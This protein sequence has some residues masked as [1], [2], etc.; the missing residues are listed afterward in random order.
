MTVKTLV[1]TCALSTIALTA[2][3][4]AAPDFTAQSTDPVIQWNR[5]LLAIVPD[6]WC[7]G[8]HDSSTRSF[9]IMHAAIY[10]AVNAIDQTHRPY[11]VQFSGVSQQASQPAAADAAAH[12]VLVALYPGLTSKLDA[13]F[14]QSL[15]LVPDGAGKT[16]GI[17]IG[18]VAADA[19]L[20]LRS[21]DGASEQ[22]IPYVFGTAPGDY[23]STPPN[24]PKQ[25]Q[26]TH[27]RNVTLFALRRADRF[28]RR[29]ATVDERSI[30]IGR[31]EV[32]LLGVCG[33]T[34]RPMRR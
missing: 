33:T 31:D 4:R 26:F 30:Q 17:R 13:E 3:L 25:P 21:S 1:T 15:T 16:E 6:T 9:A 27:W 22:P 10:D 19:I 8:R 23:Q 32:Q 12:E 18:Q 34:P 14:Q 24:F 20:A 5:G 7:P 2:A 11:A 28:A 29:S